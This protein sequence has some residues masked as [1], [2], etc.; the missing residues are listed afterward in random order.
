MHCTKNSFL[1]FSFYF[2]VF[3]FL[4]GCKKDRGCDTPIGD[5]SCRLELSD[6][7]LSDLWSINGY[8]YIHGGNKGICVTHPTSNE[9][10]AFE[11]TCPNDHD[12]AV[13]MR[14]DS[15]GLI[16][17]CPACGSCFLSIDGTPLDGSAT[18]CSLFQ[19]D[20]R[21]DGTTL[22]IW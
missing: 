21:L 22:D 10:R 19:Y 4:V 3:S 15:D 9:Y 14:A 12:V 20:T 17:E 18:S 1:L 13:V 16:L 2:L 5:A 8:V 11:R 7:S 6:A